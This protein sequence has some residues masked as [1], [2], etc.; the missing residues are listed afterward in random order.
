MKVAIVHEWFDTIAGSERVVHDLLTLFP[1]ADLFAVVDFLRVQ[2]RHWIMHKP[3]TTTFIQKLP[4]AKKHFRK[5]LSLMPFAISQLDL[6]GYDLIISS[7]HAVAKGVITGPDQIHISYVHSPMR[8]AWDMQS[9]YLE[10]TKLNSGIKG[11]VARRMLHKLRMWDVMCSHQVDY[12]LANSA[13]IA[14]RIKKVYRR[15]ATVL[16][17]GADLSRFAIQAE[18]QDYYLAASRIVPYKKMDLIV[19]AFGHMPDK[20]LIVIGGGEGL[21]EL[22]KIA[23]PN[24]QVLGAVAHAILVEHMQNAKALIFAAQEDFGFVPVEAQACGTPVIAYG[25]GGALETV[26]GL[27]LPN[28]TGLFFD[29]QTASAIIAAVKQFES[30]QGEFTP[31]NCVHNAMRFSGEVFKAAFQRFVDQVTEKVL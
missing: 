17:P 25:K 3:V 19:R 6:R 30:Q 2:D 9:E 13:F 16:H 15:D 11:W 14:K 26:I 8:Y 4:L 27:G 23:T 29:E 22:Q 1:D 31:S 21:A 28:P 18:K 12:F 5:Y 20:K 24:V 7:H 10:Q